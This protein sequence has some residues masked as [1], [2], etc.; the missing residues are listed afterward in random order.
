M[1]SDF[2]NCGRAAWARLR[3]AL[4]Y[5]LMAFLFA[6][7]GYAL[8]H[9]L[10]PVDLKQVMAQVRSTPWHIIALSFLA[11]LTGYTALIGYDWSALNYLDKK[12][13]LPTIITGGF[14]GYALGNTIGAGPV[15][16]GAVRYRIYSALGLTGYDIAA[17]AVFGS[18][19]FGIGATVVG[20]GALAYHPY[21][22]KSLTSISPAVL[23]WIGIVAVLVSLGLIVALGMRKS[24][25]KLRGHTFKPP[26]LS[27][28]AGQFIFTAIDILMAAIV[29]YLL[30]PP[31]DLGFATF[32]AVFAAAIFA[33]VASHVPG[34]VGVFETIII[35]A[36]PAS[37]PIDQA[38]AGLLL[39]RLIYYLMPFALALVLLAFTE[40]TMARGKVRS[41]QLQALSP[42]FGAVSAV[43]PMAM[44]AMVLT[45]GIVMLLS[46][47]IPPTSE[48]AEQ[49]EVLVPLGFVET[50]ALLSSAIGVFLLVIAHGMLRR[51]EGAYWLAILALGAGIAASLMQGL[52]YD[53]AAV[54]SV[55]L[56]ILLPCRREFFRS[57][58]LTRNPL[59]F[60]W[61]LLVACIGGA[62]WAVFFF[63]HKATPYSH[64]LWWQFAADQSAPRALR[65]GFVASVL[66]CI[67]MLFLAMRPS[68]ATVGLA[69]KDDL[70]R[71]KTIIAA[72]DNP[73]ANFVLTGDKSILF[74]DCGQAFLMYRV[75][76]RSWIVLGDPVGDPNASA[77]LVWAFQDMANAANGRPVFYE[78]SSEHLPLWAEVGFALHKMG[79]EAVVALEIFSLDGSNRKKLRTTFN[80]AGRDGLS[81]QILPAPVDDE[82]LARM[83]V[84][85]D[86]WLTEKH[87]KEK[88]FS[89]G[90]FDD[91]Y[92]RQFPI[93]VV[94]HNGHLVAFANV[95]TT[96][97]KKTATIDLM[98]HSN[99]A[100]S[101]LMEYLFTDLMLHLKAEGFTSFSLGMAPLSGLESRRGSRWTMKLGSLIYR[102]GGHFYNFEGLRGFKNKFEPEWHSR[103]L[104]VSPHTNILAV[105]T[106]AAA[107][108]SGGH[109]IHE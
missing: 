79:E 45:S 101:S 85:S 32:L 28:M 98:R 102:H 6:M 12:L 39:Y 54:L 65:A 25:I 77:E 48:L 105:A 63:G 10:K 42:I 84:I 108:V 8:Y 88:Q 104:A 66:I 64:D 17:I 53:R 40:L 36:L 57:T 23:R 71:A 34:G 80:R 2:S 82:T 62:A 83:R 50:G 1:S 31:S 5:I 20:F 18:I 75:Q 86:E 19:S 16:G 96:N 87:G 27:L 90:H 35:A 33:G 41:P 107:L 51:V 81:F 11:T 68:R 46:S 67:L 43:V 9:L 15:T 13:P 38:A 52:D 14:L 47:L 93:A 70:D 106:D 58:R 103:F 3:P 76:G 44:S 100:P 26:S 55:M 72:Q 94:H 29:L 73:D 97:Q 69:T 61:L 21:A 59:S 37:V 92:L 4:P 30:L 99:D 91:D 74:S 78:V 60:R 56:L 24:E 109:K 89:V 95:L 22:L 7:G 49:L